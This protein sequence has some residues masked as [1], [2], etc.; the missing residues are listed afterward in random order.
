MAKKKLEETSEL[1]LITE[2]WT[3]ML[4]TSAATEA[5]RRA[6]LEESDLGRTTVW[7]I[8]QGQPNASVAAA[9]RVRRTI[10]RLHPEAD[11][12]PPV[13]AVEDRED[14]LWNRIKDRLKERGDF[15]EW[16]DQLLALTDVLTPEERQN[17]AMRKLAA[18][19]HPGA[20][21]KRDA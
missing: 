21:K 2:K 17:R 5:D 3:E 7:R 4:R 11:L 8:F 13:V 16:L 1:Q 9:E 18:M 12:P 14:W 20:P 19:R 6:V 15:S 10:N